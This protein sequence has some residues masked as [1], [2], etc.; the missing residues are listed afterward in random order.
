ML[1]L[2]YL[3][4]DECVCIINDKHASILTPI[5]PNHAE[6]VIVDPKDGAQDVI[7][8]DDIGWNC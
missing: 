4:H 8:G 3:L 5:Q 1:S 6:I 2:I 7:V